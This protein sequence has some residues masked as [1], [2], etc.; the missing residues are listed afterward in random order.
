MRY[1]MCKRSLLLALWLG[2]VLL[3]GAAPSPSWCQYEVEQEKPFWVRGLIDLRIA[4]GGR[5]H[6]WTSRGP[7]KTRYG[8]RSTAEGSE[9]VTRLSVAQ[10]ALEG[11]AA[12]P[13]DVTAHAQLNWYP[14]SDEDNKPLLIEAYFRK[15]W[16]E[17]EKGWG[18]QTGVLSPPFS[19]EHTGPAWTSPYT[20][21]PS[22]LNTWLWEELRVVGLEGEWWR[23]TAGGTRLSLLAGLGFGADSF[24]QLLPERGWV[25]SDALRGVNSVLPLPRP[26]V[27]SFVF[28]ERDYRP[29]LY[30]EL[31]LT[32]AQKRAE[33]KLGYF[34]NLGDQGTTGTWAT[35]FGNFGA[36]LHPLARVDLLLQYLIG[37]TH[38]YLATWDSSFSAFYALLSYHYRSHR[39]SIRYDVFRVHDLDGGPRQSRERGDA[40]TL[41]YLFEFGLHHRVGF[42]YIFAHSHHPS[43]SQ[44]DPSDGGWQLSYRFRY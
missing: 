42:E 36:I 3:C 7:G 38:T 31:N 12:L 25:L 2:A 26:G 20:L 21:T 10:F 30:F 15:E 18:V 29:A 34:D 17:W 41:A 24:G 11:G 4:Q 39:F 22:A 33:L 40:F 32:E 13:W 9:R 14:D 1:D 19:L 6:A 43:L 28:D 37:E 35:R 23:A 8:G 5:A 27:N 44:S 16:G